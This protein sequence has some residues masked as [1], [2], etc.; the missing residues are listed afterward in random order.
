MFIKEACRAN[1]LKRM[2]L[3]LLAAILVF[4]GFYVVVLIIKASAHTVEGR[5]TDTIQKEGTVTPSAAQPASERAADRFR[6]P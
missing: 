4:G 1:P 2:A 5:K 3:G 6:L